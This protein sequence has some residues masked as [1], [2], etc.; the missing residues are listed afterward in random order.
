MQRQYRLIET[1]VIAFIA[2]VFASLA[3]GAAGLTPDNWKLVIPG[4]AAAAVIAGLKAVVVAWTNFSGAGLALPVET[5]DM[6]YVR[7]WHLKP[8][9]I[10]PMSG[11]WTN[12]RTRKQTTCVRGER[13]PPD[14]TGS[15]WSLTD[16]T[17]HGSDE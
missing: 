8:G 1:L 3:A 7:T 5:L 15:Y 13:M 17:R 14:P 10:C 9:Q 2:A 16:R 4:I 12:S 6:P 11:Q